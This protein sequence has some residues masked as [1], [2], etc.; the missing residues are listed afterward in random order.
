VTLNLN[1]FIDGNET[2][3]ANTTAKI[4]LTIVK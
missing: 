4:K 2:A 3:K 1:V